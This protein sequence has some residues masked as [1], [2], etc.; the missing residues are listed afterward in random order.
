VEHDPVRDERLA[1]VEGERLLPVSRRLRDLRPE[2]PDADLASVDDVLSVELA[3]PVAKA[4]EDGWVEPA[5]P[6]G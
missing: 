5:A 2:K 3:D 4:A 6:G 1:A